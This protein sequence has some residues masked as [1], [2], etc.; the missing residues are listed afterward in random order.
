MNYRDPDRADALAAQYVLG[1]LRG[2]AR[3]R[4][5]RL[6]RTDRGLADA[7]SVWEERLLPFS[8]S[9][10]PIEPPARVWSQIVSRIQPG[11][12]SSTQPASIW[13]DL[14]LWRGLTLVGF[15]TAMAMAIVLLS[16]P[17][18]ADQA[19][20]AVLAGQDAR[21]VLIASVDRTGRTLSI[22][23]VAPLQLDP[24]RALEL[25]AL[26]QGGAPRSLGLISASG[27]VQI[28]LTGPAD[29]ALAQVPALAVS[30]EPRGGSPTGLPTGPVLYSGPIQR[31]F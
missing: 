12:S 29:S 16:P 14:R 31:L 19:L 27:V 9:L 5:V 26:P 7:V 1:T 18:R 3:D 20:V 10:P 23:P 22:K 6:L 24:D 30:L 2:R 25:W 21:P 28:P 17:Q 11:R 4:F 8:E 13:A 15:V